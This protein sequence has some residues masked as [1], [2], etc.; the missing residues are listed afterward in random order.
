MTTISVPKDAL[1]WLEDRVRALRGKPTPTKPATND[2]LSFLNA[3]N[4]SFKAT[5]FGDGS[6][7]DIID[8]LGRSREGELF[9]RLFAGD[10]ADVDGDESKGDYRLA[11]FFTWAVRGDADRVE[12]L[13]RLSALVRDKWD[14]PRGTTTYLRLTI[15][16]AIAATTKFY[17]DNPGPTVAAEARADTPASDAEPP[18]PEPMAQEAYH[19]LAGDIVRTLEP[20]TES[21]PAALLIQSLV[22]FGN[23]IGRTAHFKIEGDTHYC[24][25][26][27][28]GVGPTASGRK[29]TGLGRCRQVMRKAEEAWAENITG[30]LSSSE[31]ALWAI[32]DPMKSRERV[33]GARGEPAR[34]EEVESDPGVPDKRL[35]LCETEWASVLKQA[36]R[37]GNTLS[38]ILRK[39]WDGDPV[40]RSLVKNSPAKVTGGHVSII[41]H[42]TPQELRRYMTTTEVANGFGNRH[43]YFMTR[44]S[45]VLPRGGQMRMAEI[46]RL[47]NG[48]WLAR[49]HAVAM[50]EVGMTADAWDLWDLLYGDLTRDRSGLAGALLGRGAPHVR[51]IALTYAMLDCRDAVDVAHLKAAAAV[52][53]YC[54]QSVFYLFGDSTGDPVA[55]EIYTFLTQA[56]ARGMSRNTISDHFGR[57]HSSTRIGQA[58]GLLVKGGKAHSKSMPPDGPR[59]RPAEVWFPGAGGK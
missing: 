28:V 40:I 43:L 47:Q 23:V 34:Y 33:K 57:N 9:K 4:A 26:F 56:G 30:G 41:G 48:I 59:G 44:R 8:L 38:P 6:D 12:R 13:M 35:M 17:G 29:G 19:G 32:R 36:E 18:W 50:E 20:H 14:E 2:G 42:I 10:L 22:L 25:E 51:R 27:A 15:A 16:K 3:H 54:Q 39:F 31:G 46:E 37:A 1:P 21:D 53:H 58:L 55:D 24:N 45:K 11:K 7:A 49:D 5:A 52:W